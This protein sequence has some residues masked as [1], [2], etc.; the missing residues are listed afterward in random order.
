M[1][2]NYR[3]NEWMKKLYVEMEKENLLTHFSVLI[4][5]NTDL[6]ELASE[7]SFKGGTNGFLSQG[8]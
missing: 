7:L 6:L 8:R 4:I 2:R 3:R 5:Q 1:E